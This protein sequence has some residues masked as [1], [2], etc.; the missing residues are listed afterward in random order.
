MAKGEQVVV[1]NFDLRTCHMHLKDPQ[2]F[3]YQLHVTVDHP[4]TRVPSFQ[5]YMPADKK[6][7]ENVRSLLKRTGPSCPC[8]P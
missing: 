6:I 1:P 2:V 5:F 4:D 3:Q 8:I 7:A